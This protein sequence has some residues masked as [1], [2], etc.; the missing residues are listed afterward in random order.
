MVVLR[1]KGLVIFWTLVTVVLIIAFYMMFLAFNPRIGNPL[2]TVL[3]I[4]LVYFAGIVGL[5]YRIKRRGF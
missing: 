4:S 2:I 1:G 3:V 5:W